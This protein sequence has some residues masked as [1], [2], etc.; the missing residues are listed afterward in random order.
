MSLCREILDKIPSTQSY[1]MLGDAYMNILEVF[2][3][4]NVD[5]ICYCIEMQIKLFANFN[6]VFFIFKKAR[7]SHRNLRTSTEEEPERLDTDQKSW[8]SFSKNAFL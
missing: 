6:C 7:T 1:L 8:T 2:T 3:V 5:C 4:L